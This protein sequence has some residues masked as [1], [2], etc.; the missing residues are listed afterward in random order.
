MNTLSFV[1]MVTIA[2]Y[3]LMM[4]AIGFIYSKS[5][6]D[7]TDFY[8]GGRKMGPLVT[9]M[10]AEASDMSSWLLMG[11]PGLAYFS[12]ICEPF[13]TILGLGVG[14]YLNWLVVSKKLRRYSYNIDAY[15]IPQFFSKRFHDEKNALSAIAALVIII[16]FVPYTASG[17][18]ACGKL[19]HSLFGV[20]YVVAMVA[21]ALIIT[22]YTIM[23]GFKAVSTTDFI[24]SC[25]MTVALVVVLGFAINVAGGWNA[26]MDNAKALPG[27]ISLSLYHDVA[28]NT[29]ASYGG[30]IAI[31]ST[32]AWGL[33]YF[34]M[35]HILLRFMAIENEQ[36]LSLSRRVATVWVFIAMGL[37]MI[38]GLAG[39]GVTAA[40]KVEFLNTAASAETIIVKLSDLISQNGVFAAI[41]AG[42][43]LAGIL[44]ATM[45]TAD[46]QMLAAAS[47][48]SENIMGEF[49]NVK[50]DEKKKILVARIAI[51]GIAILGVILA[52][53][54]DSSV[55]RIVSFAWAGFGGAFGPVM[56]LALFWKRTTKQGALAGMVS[57]GAM[58]FI[59]KFLI[60]PI[61]GVF[62]IYELLPAFIVSLIFT[63]V[64]SLLTKEPDKSIIEE[65]EKAA[66]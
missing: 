9:A 10:S 43:I 58:V 49:F 48:V 6:N 66:N 14:T 15:T 5:N 17:F 16:F 33:G 44:A 3:L 64:V 30:V 32:L 12:G 11:I 39:L 21:S 1:I 45:S 37:A 19:F 23:G 4:L 41:V 62:S 54:P 53:D 27:H 63:V 29:A 8:L 51:V 56:L 25:V 59:W 52:L 13:W 24:Q 26:V 55:F 18:A 47:S 7:S 38:I 50:M 65:F 42:L 36:K 34:G 46:S 35:P 60:K 31:I 28:N 2:V 57:G 22:G 40:G 20:N 61:G